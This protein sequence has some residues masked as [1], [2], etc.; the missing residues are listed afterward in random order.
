MKLAT[1]QGKYS[2]YSISIFDRVACCKNGKNRDQDELASVTWTG[3][4]GFKQDMNAE[5]PCDYMSTSTNVS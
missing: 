1:S 5:F 2:K 3:N 4:I